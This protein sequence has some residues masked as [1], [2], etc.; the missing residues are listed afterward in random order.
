MSDK[1]TNA[2]EWAA[3]HVY[4]PDALAVV[5]Y[6]ELTAIFHHVQT[7][8]AYRWRTRKVLPEPDGQ[9]SGKP[10][11]R[12]TTILAWASQTNRTFYV[13]R[14]WLLKHAP[15]YVTPVTV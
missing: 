5:G 3:D 13:E 10:A 12:L 9:V 4:V 6:S 8:T 2:L 11:W 14:A 7:D 15:D 1:R